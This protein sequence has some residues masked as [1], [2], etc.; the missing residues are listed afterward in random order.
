MPRFEVINRG[1]PCAPDTWKTCLP[2]MQAKTSKVFF[3]LRPGIFTTPQPT[4]HGTHLATIG[5]QPGAD[6]QRC[7]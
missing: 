1:C 7:R 4:R 2:K 6:N 3:G 5:C